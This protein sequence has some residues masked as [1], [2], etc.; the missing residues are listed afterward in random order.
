M[1]KR[2]IKYLRHIISNIAMSILTSLAIAIMGKQPICDIHCEYLNSI[3]DEHLYPIL[4]GDPSIEHKE[5]IGGFIKVN[6]SH[7]FLFPAL[8]DSIQSQVLGPSV[9]RIEWKLRIQS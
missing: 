8:R 1:L 2:V 5:F 7:L 3:I 6:T 4:K 9:R